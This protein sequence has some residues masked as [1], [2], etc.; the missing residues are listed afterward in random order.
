MKTTAR[1]LKMSPE[2]FIMKPTPHVIDEA[3]LT[4]MDSI[5]EELGL[6]L[7][8]SEQFNVIHHNRKQVDNTKERIE[9]LA[10]FMIEEAQL[11][12]IKP[13]TKMK[14]SASEVATKLE[15]KLSAVLA[16]V[17]ALEKV[18]ACYCITASGI[19][20]LPFTTQLTELFAELGLTTKN[21]GKVYNTATRKEA[22][23]NVAGKH[24]ILKLVDGVWSLFDSDNKKLKAGMGEIK[25]VLC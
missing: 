7:S 3:L 5:N 15:H 8:P 25:G 13:Y 21:L 14:V 4:C 20:V 12:R 2:E 19:K 23:I 1:N 18:G 9:D 10:E 16:Q 6:N 11:K 17:T 24:Y 22:Q